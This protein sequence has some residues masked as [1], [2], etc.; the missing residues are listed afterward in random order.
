MLC[1]FGPRQQEGQFEEISNL[2]PEQ[3]QDDG[4]KKSILSKY[5]M[6]PLEQ[7][8]DAGKY[9]YMYRVMRTASLVIKDGKLIS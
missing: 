2:T 7:N 1:D 3:H 9:N 4:L 8:F 6:V 5:N